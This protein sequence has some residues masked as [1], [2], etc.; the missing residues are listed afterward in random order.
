[1]SPTP[2]EQM[3]PAAFAVA[4][5]GDA[6]AI[7]ALVNA[8]YRPTSGRIGWTHERDLVGGPRIKAAQVV[9]AISQPDSVLLV[10]SVTTGIA[11]CVHLQ[12]RGEVC[13][14]GLLA[15]DP[16]LQGA[17][18]GKRMLGQAEQFAVDTWGC[19]TI[20]ISVLSQRAELLA[21]YRRRGYRPTGTVTDYPRAQGV[22]LP[23]V[24][25]LTVDTL[26]KPMP[27]GPR[28]GCP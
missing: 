22:G 25:G 8:A 14:L 10:A 13:L 6:V 7:A 20:R 18:I 4:T 3:L 19:T 5:A 11:A 9:D 17:G 23:I 2:D 21:Y 1:M 15:V 27:S 24:E 16:G 12:K 28:T 26:D